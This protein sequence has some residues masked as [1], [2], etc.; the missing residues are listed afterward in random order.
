M[1]LNPRHEAEYSVNDRAGI[2]T[3]VPRYPVL[4]TF[5]FI[6]SSSEIFIR[7]HLDASMLD[8]RNLKVNRK[9]IVLLFVGL[10]V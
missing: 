2:Q 1:Q 6:L 3:E 4:G 10:T 7:H 8:F 5:Q 9:N